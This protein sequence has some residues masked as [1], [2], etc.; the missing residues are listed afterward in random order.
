MV[1]SHSSGRRD[2]SS[3]R[4]VDVVVPVD[5]RYKV[6]LLAVLSLLE[7]YYKSTLNWFNTI[8]N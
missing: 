8:K 6:P 2:A 4:L 5:S 7:K 3:R 1:S